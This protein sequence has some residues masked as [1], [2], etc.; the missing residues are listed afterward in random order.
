MGC[1]MSE[2]REFF[3]MLFDA[4]LALVVIALITVTYVKIVCDGV[5]VCVFDSSPRTCSMIYRSRK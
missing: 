4:L 5:W 1:E 3:E 2:F